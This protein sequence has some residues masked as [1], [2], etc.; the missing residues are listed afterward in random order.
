TPPFKALGFH[1]QV[2]TREV[3]QQRRHQRRQPAGLLDR[4]DHNRPSL[5]RPDLVTRDDGN[6]W[7]VRFPTETP[8]WVEFRHTPDHRF[9]LGLADPHTASDAESAILQVVDCNNRGRPFRPAL[10]VHQY[11]PYHARWLV[12]FNTNLSFHCSPLS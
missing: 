9:Q 6:S 7:T 1:V 3:S 5:R 11:R 4:E 2:T 8:A 10:N 12:D